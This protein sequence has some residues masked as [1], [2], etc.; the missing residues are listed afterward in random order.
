MRTTND[1]NFGDQNIV[2]G[3]VEEVKI[4]KKAGE[5]SIIATKQKKKLNKADFMFK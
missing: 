4:L 5:E 1:I 2:F 3:P